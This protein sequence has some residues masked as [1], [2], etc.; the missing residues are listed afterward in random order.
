MTYRSKMTA[1]GIAAITAIGFGAPLTASAAGVGA[2]VGVDAGAQVS[3]D[4]GSG[5]TLSTGAG[6]SG[7]A[8][9]QTPDAGAVVDTAKG[10][11][12]SGAMTVGSVV[13][14]LEASA[15]ASAMSDVSA[16]ISG[17]NAATQVKLVTLANLETGSQALTSQVEKAIEAQKSTIGQVQ[18]AI[19]ENAK[20]SAALSAKGYAASDVVGVAQNAGGDITIVVDNAG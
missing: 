4:T 17:G 8:A 2:S 5:V 9:A 6:A 1:A 14:G 18:K 3:S 10:A 11:A 12:Q 13:S 16:K 15:K 20:L 7:Q 19:S